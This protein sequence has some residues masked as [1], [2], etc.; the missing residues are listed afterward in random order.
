MLEGNLV[1]SLVSLAIG[2]VMMG[3]GLYVFSRNPYSRISSTFIIAMSMGAIAAVMDFFILNSPDEAT[4]LIFGR[5]AFFAVTCMFG[6]ILY[7]SAYLPDEGG[8]GWFVDNTVIYSIMVVFSGFVPAAAIDQAEYSSFGYGIPNIAGFWIW[9]VVMV[10]YTVTTVYMLTVVC[11]RSESR[12][13]KQQSTILALGV[14]APLVY[15]FLMTASDTFLGTDTPPLLS[16]GFLITGLTFT[17]VVFKH[18]LFIIEPTQEVKLEVEP[19]RTRTLHG[20]A[21]LL[22]E[23]KKSDAAYDMFMNEIAA[24]SEGI[25]VSRI[26]PDQLKERYGL[27]KTPIIWLAS[28]PGPMRIDP[29][30]LSILQH[31]IVDFLQKGS[32]VVVLLDG[33]EYLI[34]NNAVDKVLRLVYSLRDA[35]VISQSRLLIPLDPDILGERDRAL[36]ERELEVVKT[37][38]GAGSEI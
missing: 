26:H 23:G 2:I 3:L 15:G 34:S 20:G 32:N 24:G 21:C 31:T 17:Y 29:T 25:L 33:L 27:V 30:S 19:K 4:A 38:E 18:K 12:D 22:V 6:A 14:A 7:L 37:G 1:Y 35:V 13:I 16:P 11:L 10:F 5:L 8:I 9:V 28:Q 36:F